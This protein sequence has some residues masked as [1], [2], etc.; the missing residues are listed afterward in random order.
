MAALA[1]HVPL[2]ICH[3]SHTLHLAAPLRDWKWTPKH[4]WFSQNKFS[5][6]IKVICAHHRKPEKQWK[7]QDKCTAPPIHANMLTDCC[8][9]PSSPSLKAIHFYWK[10]EV[11][12]FPKMASISEESIKAVKV[13]NSLRL[14][15]TRRQ[16][17]CLL[18]PQH[19]CVHTWVRYCLSDPWKPSGLYTMGTPYLRSLTLSIKKRTPPTKTMLF[20]YQSVY[21]F[22]GAFLKIFF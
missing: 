13:G 5:S 1:P 20:Q 18:T 21:H 15:G 6:N 8:P 14:A 10:T 19:E 22:K 3:P 11:T 12:L 16:C 4:S 2:S 17:K 7:P 9:C